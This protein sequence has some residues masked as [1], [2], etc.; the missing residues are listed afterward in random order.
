M[1]T[2][3]D[4]LAQFLAET[5]EGNRNSSS[6]P[7]SIIELFTMYLD[8]YGH[9]DLKPFDAARFEKEY[10]EDRGFCEIFGPAHIEP[11]HLNSF[12]GTFVPRKV[13]ASKSLLKA[14]GP[15]IEKLA[16]WL[17][18]RG[19]WT[20]AD[21]AYFRSLVSG[22]AGADL[23]DCDAFGEAVSV[24]VE[25]HPPPVQLYDVPE[26][27]YRPDQFMIAKVEPGKLHVVGMTDDKE[28]VLSLPKAITDNAKKGWWVSLE[29]VRVRGKWRISDVG[30]VSP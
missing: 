6:S 19:H 16:A 2:I 25:E 28:I 13:A 17:H 21:T 18:D 27:D 30:Q 9:V 5:G 24:Y 4:T 3:L 14:C 8:S 11:Y 15:L 26:E 23:V 7:A 1:A 20:D 10:G 12:L 22:K 29:L